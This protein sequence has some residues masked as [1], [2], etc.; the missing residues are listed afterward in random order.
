MNREVTIECDE[1]NDNAVLL[2][3]ITN[4]KLNGVEVVRV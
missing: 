4:D 2:P 1:I 3:L